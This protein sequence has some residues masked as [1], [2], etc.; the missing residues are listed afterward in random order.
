MLLFVIII[1]VV[2]FFVV[3]KFYRE[4]HDTVIAYTGGLGSGKSLKS[5]Q[6]SKRLYRMQCRKVF[7]HN[8]FHKEKW[9]KPC[10]YSSIPLRI[11]RKEY[12]KMLTIGHLTLVERLVP[13][14]VVFID[15]IGSFASQ[16]EYN[17]PVIMDNFD[18]FVR[19]F[20]HYTKGGYLVVN[21][22]CSENIVLQVRR[23][24]NEVKNLCHCRVVNLFFFKIYWISCRNISVSEE[25]KTIET[26]HKESA[27]SL[28]FGFLPRYKYYDTY[29]YS[30]RYK[31]VPARNSRGWNYL[32]TNRVLRAPKIKIQKMTTDSE[33]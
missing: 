20:R 23:R 11:S 18:E 1:C 31:T 2:L 15:E 4:K 7:W 25:I 30:E 3:R 13:R 21:D 22:Q 8:L 10:L 17:N 26:E 33:D 14:S 5:A 24:L 32:K 9:E 19:F 16:F 29:T 27:T 28:L 12:A 6:M